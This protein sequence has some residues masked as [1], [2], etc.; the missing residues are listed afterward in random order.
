VTGGYVYRG[1][2]VPAAAGRYFYGDYCSGIIWSLKNAGSRASSVRREPFSLKGLS[3]FGEGSAGELY[4][5]SVTSGDL[6][7]LR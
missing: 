7:R 6:Y 5:M 1:A 3:S 4:L 2:N